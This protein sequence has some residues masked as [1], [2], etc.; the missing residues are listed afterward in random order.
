MSERTEGQRPEGSQNQEIGHTPIVKPKA[1]PG[2]SGCQDDHGTNVERSRGSEAECCDGKK[3][4]AG[5]EDDRRPGTKE[6]EIS[7]ETIQPV[8]A[9]K[10]SCMHLLPLRVRQRL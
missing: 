8:P 1:R 5:S 2:K 6:P 3:P 7:L 4:Q 9:L 10:N